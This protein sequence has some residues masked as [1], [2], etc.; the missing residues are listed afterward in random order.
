[1]GTSQN[2]IS[3]APDLVRGRCGEFAAHAPRLANAKPMQRLCPIFVIASD[4]YKTWIPA[5]AGMTGLIEVLLCKRTQGQSARGPPHRRA[6]AV[7]RVTFRI[8]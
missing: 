4:V 3:V 1:V 2:R 6:S 8:P 7:Y 5:C